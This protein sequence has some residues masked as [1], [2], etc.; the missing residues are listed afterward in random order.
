MIL[1]KNINSHIVLGVSLQEASQ[2]L[3]GDLPKLH[4][5]ILSFSLG[6]CTTEVGFLCFGLVITISSFLL[7]LDMSLATSR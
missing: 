7:K 4:F 6:E 5:V 3:M 2:K 1:L